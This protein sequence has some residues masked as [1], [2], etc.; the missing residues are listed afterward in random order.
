MTINFSGKVAVITGAGN[1]L[2]RQ[3]ALLLASLGAKVVVNDLGAALDGMAA[4][5][6]PAEK[7]AAEIRASGGEARA[8]GDNVTDPEG[9]A[10]M[11]RQA[12]DAFGRLDILVCNAGILRDRS[13]LKMS[14]DDFAQVMDVHMTGAYLCVKAAAPAMIEQ[15]FGRIV[16]TTSP[17]GLF[18]N[19]GQSNYGAAKMALV[20]FANTLKLELGRKG[21]LVNCIAPSAITRMTE[22]ILDEEHAEALLPEYVA[23]MVAYLCSDAC[24][25]N[26][27]IF[28]AGANH[29]AINRMVQGPGV[30]FSGGV[31]SIDDIAGRISEISTLEGA[32]PYQSGV[33]HTARLMEEYRAA[34]ASGNGN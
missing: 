6:S 16:L 21:V 27:E 9:A 30:T 15:G 10:R 4:N 32:L 29:F 26:G 25:C 7:V 13:L 22:S 17:S 2:G 23:P 33:D 19:F 20:G 1:G 24:S 3:Y 34:N 11:V 8:N 14:N 28:A 5:N 12:I 31:P 18:G